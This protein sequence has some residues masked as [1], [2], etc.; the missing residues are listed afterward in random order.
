MGTVGCLH[1]QDGRLH[2]DYVWEAELAVGLVQAKV[3]ATERVI[4]ILILH[5]VDGEADGRTKGAM[6]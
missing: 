5:L 3:A 6:R 1:W 4:L 2:L